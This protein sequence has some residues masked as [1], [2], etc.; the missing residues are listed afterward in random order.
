MIQ[1][2]R[3][4]AHLMARKV[5]G[6]SAWP[7]QETSGWWAVRSSRMLVGTCPLSDPF[8]PGIPV[9][10]EIHAAMCT[11]VCKT[12]R[13]GAAKRSM[14]PS[15]VVF[16]LLRY[17]RSQQD[18]LNKVC[19]SCD[20]LKWRSCLFRNARTNESFFPKDFCLVEWNASPVETLMRAFT[21][22]SHAW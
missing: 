10:C 5:L 13:F 19:W 9:G 16:T 15:P 18:E 12:R 7:Q 1:D 22:L 14:W 20:H 2:V 21:H 4:T 3:R 11:S 6:P 8:R 17:H